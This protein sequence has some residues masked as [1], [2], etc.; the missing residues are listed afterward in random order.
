M[1][2]VVKNLQVDLERSGLP[3]VSDITFTLLPGKVLGIVGESGSGKTTV[4]LAMLGYARKGTVIAIGSEIS[5]NGTDILSLAPAKL[6]AARS[7]LVAYVPQDPSASLNPALEVGTQ[8]LESLTTGTDPISKGEALERVA[9]I[10]REVNLPDTS[11]FLSCYPSQ[12]SGGQQQRVA[13]AMA[14]ATR[15][16]LIVLDEP[17]TGL[18]VS[19]QMDVLTMV[20]RLCAAHDIAAIYVSHDLA[21]ISHVADDVLVLY[22]GRVMEM[23]PRGL[24]FDSPAH[25][26]TRALLRSLPSITQRR[27]LIAIEGNT[28]SLD[29]R[30]V[31]C[32]FRSRC[33]LATAACLAE[34]ALSS[35]GGSGSH[36]VRCHYPQVQPLES[37][38][39]TSFHDPR[40]ASSSLLSI[41]NLSASYGQKSILRNISLDLAA[42]ECLAIV[43]ES[44][45]GKTTL[46]RCLI[47]LHHRWSGELLFSGAS[48]EQSSGQRSKD[49]RRRIQYIFQNPYGSINP[50][51]TVGD[52]IAVAVDHFF[53]GKD[54]IALGVT[55]ALERVGL[56]AEFAQRFPNELSG[57]EKQRI[58]IARALVC[59]PD[60]LVCDEITSALD[61]SVQ[62][63]IVELLRSLMKEGLAI[64]F[65]TH[66]LAVIRSLA[67][68]V[69]V[70]NKG[71]IAEL[72]GT[73]QLMRSPTSEYTRHLLSHALDVKSST[74]LE[75]VS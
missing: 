29:D 23:A 67:D 18:D 41:R 62:A 48:L 17:T 45:S 71:Q 55:A 34:P 44:G 1:T 73:E 43:G 63:A 52:S 40:V 60:I 24:Q 37:A 65:V 31:G 33:S 66:N 70:L 2:I 7:G 10:L 75:P 50:R 74:T 51:Y 12:I 3:L 27:T 72:A 35:V 47:G 57:G 11:A 28:P 64:V 15:P 13:I 21:V 6:R 68:R 30:T 42:G 54:G 61:V 8:L 14:V 16:R 19:T 20:S 49:V 4:S 59:S 38:G 39:T 5:I 36:L 56:S 58:A 25:P 22:A 26:Y 32:V 9:G 46:S 53:G 69:A